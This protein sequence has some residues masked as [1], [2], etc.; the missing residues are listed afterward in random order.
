M[1]PKW[2]SQPFLTDASPGWRESWKGVRRS[3]L[4][5]CPARISMQSTFRI[6]MQSWELQ[7]GEGFCSYWAQ[8]LTGKMLGGE[9]RAFEEEAVC[10][11]LRRAVFEHRGSG[12]SKWGTGKGF[13]SPS[14]VKTYLCLIWTH[15]TF[16]AA[17][18]T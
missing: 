18:L 9:I 6:S 4:Y 11:G 14:C 15:R 3:C 8:C 16:L 13:L 17:W 12:G 2:G 10:M 1:V 7:V 5:I